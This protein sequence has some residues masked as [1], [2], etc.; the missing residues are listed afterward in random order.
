MFQK[1]AGKRH[2]QIGP[3]EFY[4]LNLA[5]FSQNAEYGTSVRAFLGILRGPLAD[6]FRMVWIVGNRIVRER[7]PGGAGFVWRTGYFYEFSIQ[8]ADQNFSRFS[9]R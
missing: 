7:V 2:T 8:R 5:K 1:S 4:L 3:H 9:D 6:L